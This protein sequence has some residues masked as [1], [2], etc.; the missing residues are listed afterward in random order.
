[1]NP[2]VNEE[3]T[4]G[5]GIQHFLKLAHAQLRHRCKGLETSGVYSLELHRFRML[6]ELVKEQLLDENIDST[7]R[8]TR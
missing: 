7:T 6:T 2:K 3:L 4:P 8:Q 1:M 5:S